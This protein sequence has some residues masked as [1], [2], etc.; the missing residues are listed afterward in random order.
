MVIRG[1]QSPRPLICNGLSLL[2][3]SLFF[4]YYSAGVDVSAD[5]IITAFRLDFPHVCLERG[6]ARN[7]YLFSD[8]LVNPAGETVLT[9]L[10]GGVTQGTKVNCTATGIHSESFAVWLRSTFP[11]HELIR[12]DVA[13]DFNEGGAWASLSQ[14]GIKISNMFSLKSNYMGVP[15]KETDDCHDCAGRTLY[16]GSRQ[17]VGMLRLYEKGKK[18]NPDHPDWVRAELEFKPKGTEQR[19]AYAKASKAEIVHA[20]RWSSRFFEVI[21]SDSVARPCS[22]GTVRAKTD[23]ERA[24]EHAKAQYYRLFADKLESLGGCPVAFVAF[25]MD[26]PAATTGQHRKAS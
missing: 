3:N 6:K 8:L 14:W 24:L 15:H 26:T 17:S 5:K 7:G 25:L 12:A 13:L 20:I 10:H 11:E 23:S 9:L 18:D 2:N 4:D 22:P 1:S 16:I 21:G 19:L